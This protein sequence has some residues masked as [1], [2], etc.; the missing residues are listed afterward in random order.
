MFQKRFVPEKNL[1]LHFLEISDEVSR[2]GQQFGV[3]IIPYRDSELPHFKKLTEEKQLDVLRYL[4]HQRDFFLMA[5]LDGLHPNSPQLVWRTLAKMGM[6]PQ[7]DIFDKMTDENVVEVYHSDNT[8]SF[9]NLKFFEFIS[10]S[11]EEI[12]CLTWMEQASISTAIY[13][14]FIEMGAR[15]KLGKINRTFAPRF[16]RY[17]LREKLGEKRIFNIRVEWISPVSIDGKQSAL[18][19]VNRSSFANK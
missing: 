13:L 5:Q 6:T 4:S 2:L 7:P 8:T 15:L 17:Q 10:F 18:I 11:L 14:I 3:K 9:K 16:S 19:F 12:Y 1:Q